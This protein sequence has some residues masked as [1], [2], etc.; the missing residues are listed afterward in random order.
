MLRVIPN[1]AAEQCFA[2]KGGTAINLFVRDMPRLSID[3]DLTYLP[4]EPRGS[5]LQNITDALKRIATS[6]KQ[7]IPMVR[8]QESNVKGSNEWVAHAN[9]HA[10]LLAFALEHRVDIVR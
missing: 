2:L 7:A 6:I 10:V 1:V 4:I 3:I 5:S 9:R 8:V